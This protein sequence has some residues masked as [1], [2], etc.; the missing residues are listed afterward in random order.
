MNRFLL[1]LW[2]LLSLPKSLQLRIM[3]LREAQFLVS[4]VGIIFNADDKI[5]LF[6]HSYRK[7]PWGLPGGYIKA[8]E[9]PKEALEREIREESGLVVSADRQLKIRTDR[10][11]SRLEVVLT[12]EYLTGE[13]SP[14][15]EVTKS[16]FFSF[17]DLPQIPGNQLILIRRALDL[18]KPGGRQTVSVPPRKTG[19]LWGTLRRFVANI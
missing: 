13:F 5:L 15:S 12:G 14:S 6:H 17:D 4:V 10:E 11:T 2:R 19:P 7:N 9:H 16:G 18:R 8:K 3:R 1:Q